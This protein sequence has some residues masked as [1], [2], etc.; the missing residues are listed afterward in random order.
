M[1][2][3]M[4]LKDDTTH[5]FLAIV[6]GVFAKMLDIALCTYIVVVTLRWLG[7]NI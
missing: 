3:K 5:W 7:V 1:H 4:K 2:R 6:L